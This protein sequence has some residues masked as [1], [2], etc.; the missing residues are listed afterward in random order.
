MLAAPV[1]ENP[2]RIL[3]TAPLALALAL[4]S[5]LPAAAQEGGGGLG[6]AVKRLGDR[7][8]GAGALDFGNDTGRYPNDGECD[9]NPGKKGAMGRV[10]A[11]AG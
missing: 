1:R 4:A 11:S 6:D 3:H 9:D 2:M 7:L 5:A 8:A 10:V